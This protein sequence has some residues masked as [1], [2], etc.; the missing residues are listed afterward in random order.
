M[1]PPACSS[2]TP[3]TSLTWCCQAIT[4]SNHEA[5]N[6][7]ERLVEMHQAT[8]STSLPL[9]CHEVLPTC[10]VWGSVGRGKGAVLGLLG[11]FASPLCRFR[12]PSR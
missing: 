10:M 5:A 1:S 11:G 9:A 6:A 3:S 7:L 2:V 4:S 8:L 12:S